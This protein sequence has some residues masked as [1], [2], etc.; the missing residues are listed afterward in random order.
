MGMDKVTTLVALLALTSW[1]PVAPQTL[2]KDSLSVPCPYFDTINITGGVFDDGGNILF[3][4]ILYPP[5]LFGTYDYEMVNRT[6]KY[7]VEPHI[8][9]CICEIK[10]NCIK[11]CC[12]KNY[13]YNRGECSEY[14]ASSPILLDVSE[15]NGDV[16]ENVNVEQRFG[17]V[18]GKP[19]GAMY[20]LEP[21]NFET[22]QFELQ[23]SGTLKLVDD[24]PRGKNEYCIARTIA[25]NH[26]EEH[27]E[28][29][30]RI[31]VCFPD[32]ENAKFVIYPIGMLL[33]V[34]FLVVT[35]LVY[36][37]IPELR[38]LHG[39]CLMCYVL[40]LTVG[41]TLLSLIHLEV[42]PS[43]FICTFMG[44][45]AYF[46]FLVSFFWLNVMCIDIWWTFRG[47]RG[48][49]RDA[50]RKKYI[51]YSVYAWG[52]AIVILSISLTMQ[53]IDAVPDSMKPGIGLE[54]CFLKSEK[55]TEFFYLYLPVIILI[56][57]NLILFALTS[58][59]IRTLQKE[60]AA[61]NKGDSRR[62]NKME[63]DR[64]RF[65]LY[66][67]LFIV[68]GVTWTME[69][70]SWLVDPK[71]WIFYISDVC[72]CLQGFFIFMLFVWKPKIK[73][74]IIKRYRS[75][76]GLPV[77]SKASRSSTRTSTSHV[78]MAATTS[79]NRSSM[80]ANNNSVSEKSHFMTEI[81]D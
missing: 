31:F 44:F 67:R 41:Y 8:R 51:I 15:E 34:P 62:F 46:S 61:M 33:S 1:S 3:D 32:Q 48:I 10:Q 68:M 5:H 50:D 40:G 12:P 28:V 58:F 29:H 73:Q 13:V 66:L 69:V 9:G 11:Y 52:C 21:E 64:D 6:T 37:I 60:T 72:N 2:V 74:L 77:S 47:V 39:K 23:Y 16:M 71:S 4:G 79:I 7:S 25:Q 24:A 57:I 42:P 75:Y 80:K 27:P 78:S 45:T 17:I 70:I 19:C 43:N 81:G 18:Y 22:D 59:Q 26:T 35:F 76:R 53:F 63:A 65:S 56:S 38:N 20:A 14:R 49:Q 55:L 36:A 30:T 54:S